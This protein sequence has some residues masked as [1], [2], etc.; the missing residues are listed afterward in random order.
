MLIRKAS[1]Q[2]HKRAPANLA[3]PIDDVAQSTGQKSTSARTQQ[4]VK[5]ENTSTANRRL[6]RGFLYDQIDPLKAASMGRDKLQ[7]QIETLIRRICD[8]KRLQVSRSEEEQ[9]ASELLKWTTA[10]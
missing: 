3:T 5:P 10:T 6:L 2:A 7:A 4:A 8:E 9:V 1:Q